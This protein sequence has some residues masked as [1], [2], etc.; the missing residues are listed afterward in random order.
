MPANSRQICVHALLEWEKG[1]TFADD[2]LHKELEKVSFSPSDRATFN[3]HGELVLQGRAGRL[4]KIAG[5][6]LD[7]GDLERALR[8]IPG[9]NDAFVALHPQNI[10]ELAAVL[11]TSIDAAAL[12]VL[13]RRELA[14]W[15][16]PRRVVVVPEFPLT[17]RGKTD[18]RALQALLVR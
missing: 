4:V 13:L 7:L 5:R 11:A 8:T 9:V 12:R 1:R 3:E 18:A 15:K 2:I 17:A 6:R 14:A 16:V 10:D